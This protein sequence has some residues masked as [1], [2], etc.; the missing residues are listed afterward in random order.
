VTESDYLAYFGAFTGAVGAVTGIVGAVA[1]VIAYRRT[2]Q[3]KALELQLE[4]RKATSTLHHQV[5]DL[6]PLLLK[7]KKSRERVS[8]AMGTYRSGAFDEWLTGWTADFAALET[9]RSELPDANANLGTASLSQLTETLAVTHAL[10]SRAEALQTKYQDS[11]AA[12]DKSRE[13]IRAK[14]QRPG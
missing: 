7:A 13:H 1:G 5:G 3:I 8:A 10:S 9:L 12:D 2:N 6:E 14:Y 4:L 11:F